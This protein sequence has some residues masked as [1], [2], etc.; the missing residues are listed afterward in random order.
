MGYD[1]LDGHTSKKEIVKGPNHRGVKMSDAPDDKG[2]TS[3][4][5][6]RPG[7]ERHSP[8]LRL[9]MDLDVDLRLDTKVRGPVGLAVR[10]DSIFCRNLEQKS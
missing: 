5:Q 10:Y 9:D 4:S 1:A 2:P 8:A 3:T 7:N 6:K